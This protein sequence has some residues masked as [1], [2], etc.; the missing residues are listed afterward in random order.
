VTAVIDAH[1]PGPLTQKLCGI[2]PGLLNI[3]RLLQRLEFA[4]GNLNNGIQLTECDH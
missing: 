4:D 1:Q 2:Q 3:S